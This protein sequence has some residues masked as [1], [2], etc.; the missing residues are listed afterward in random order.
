[1]ASGGIPLGQWSG[2]DAINELYETLRR[3]NDIATRQA[4]TMIRLTR[5]IVVL[6]ILLFAG[7]VVQIVLALK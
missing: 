4:A 1:M 3:Y 7:L 6:T 2:S 5:A